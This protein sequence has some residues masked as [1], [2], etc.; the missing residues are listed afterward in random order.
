MVFH[1]L[2]QGLILKVVVH[3]VTASA[4]AGVAMRG[5]ASLDLFVR[6][7]TDPE[8]LEAILLA[9]VPRA[10]QRTDSFAIGKVA[11]DSWR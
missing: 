9:L 3:R 1:I 2:E 8:Q 4:A 6:P 7:G 11:A 10:S 5:I